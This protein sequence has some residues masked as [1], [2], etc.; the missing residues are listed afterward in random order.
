MESKKIKD[1][2]ESF[3]GKDLQENVIESDDLEDIFKIMFTL[4]FSKSNKLYNIVPK[5][6]TSISK[7]I[8]C[9]NISKMRKKKIESFYKNRIDA[10]DNL[11]NVKISPSGRYMLDVDF[12]NHYADY[13]Y[14][15]NPCV[16]KKIF[17]KDNF[18]L[19]EE[20]PL[21]EGKT[22]RAYVLMDV[23]TKDDKSPDL[24]VLKIIN[25]V[26]LNYY[27]SLRI[28]MNNKKSMN[29]SFDVNSFEMERKSGKNRGSYCLQVPSDNFTN[30]T[31]IHMILNRLLG[32]CPNY[33][34]QYDS[35]YCSKRTQGM[36]YGT[37]ETFDGYNI[38]EFCNYRDLSYYINK[39]KNIN[40]IVIM[41]ILTQVITPLFIL[42]QPI[43]GFLHSDLKTKNVFV[44]IVND[45][46][47]FK[48][49]D[50]DKSSIF[51]KNIRFFNN[52]FNYTING[53]VDGWNFK[54]TPFPLHKSE[55]Y[56]YYNLA[57]GD[58]ITE[59]VSFH[60]YIMSNPEGFYSSFDIYTFFYSLILEKPVSRWM[61][62][63]LGSPIWRFY[64]YLFHADEPEEWDKF[65][66]NIIELL[67]VSVKDTSRITF[68]WNQFKK[69]KYKLRYQVDEIYRLLK[70]SLDKVQN[71]FPQTTIQ[72]IKSNLKPNIDLL[73]ISND[74]HLCTIQP[75]ETEKE[76][77]TNVYSKLLGTYL[78]NYD[79]V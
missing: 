20:K 46:A 22:G 68:Y 45:K 41:D 79:F 62:S 2:V 52:T 63:N 60:E 5:N 51:Y 7:P 78:Y 69:N 16:C 67:D 1:L 44:N 42:K 34:Y 35:F 14:I 57:E 53:V 55:K 19:T 48:I 59:Y 3:I 10:F 27:L 8:W 43:F 13:F 50:F 54:T 37:K 39:L 75:V 58:Y 61:L 77:M 9:Q 15:D 74:N 11:M 71:Q 49:A 66:K 33:L 32:D 18:F 76:C 31:L 30:Q 65:M 26:R 38:T 36:L 47:I 21:G 64:K 56:L 6:S 12:L 25:N 40:E 24:F 17:E 28:M 72:I 29:E 4:D 23:R 73:Y 70:I